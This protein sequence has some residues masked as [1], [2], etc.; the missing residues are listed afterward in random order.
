MAAIL[1]CE[2]EIRSFSSICLYTGAMSVPMTFE[3]GFWYAVSLAQVPSPQPKSI[4]LEPSG[5]RGMKV[6]WRRYLLMRWKLGWR[7][8]PL[9]KGIGFRANGIGHFCIP[10]RTRECNLA[11]KDC[12]RIQF[13]AWSRYSDPASAPSHSL[14]ASARTSS[15]P[16]PVSLVA[17]QSSQAVYRVLHRRTIPS[18]RLLG[19]S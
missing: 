4:I 9:V 7:N 12:F 1:C 16:R 5:S 18:Q 14:P 8:R 2:A 3:W 10:R 13:L 15:P 17:V 6:F 11:R 19:S